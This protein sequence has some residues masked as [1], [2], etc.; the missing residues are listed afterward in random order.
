MQRETRYGPGTIGELNPAIA[1]EIGGI[2]RCR[3]RQNDFEAADDQQG[4]QAVSEGDGHV[5]LGE[6]FREPCTGIRAT[7]SCIEKDDGWLWC[8]SLRAG[9]G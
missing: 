2:I 3:V 1:G 7:V 8:R 9:G 4:L 6:F 5:A